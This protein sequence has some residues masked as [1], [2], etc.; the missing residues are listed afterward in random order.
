MI[1]VFGA[2]HQAL[3]PGGQVLILQPNIRY[4]GVSYWDFI[5]HHVA[6][7]EHSLAEGLA[8]TDFEVE[9][10][11]PRFF[12]Y[13]VKSWLGRMV[14]GKREGLLVSLYLKMPFFWRFLGKQ[15]FVQARAV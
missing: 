6:L 14:K 9:T 12:P 2:C 4:V 7:T 1:E 5:D 13:T 3:K 10:M 15:T 8:T 11:I